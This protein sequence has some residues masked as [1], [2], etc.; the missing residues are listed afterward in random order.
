MSKTSI[1]WTNRSANPIRARHK[2]TGK[3][4]WHCVKKSPGCIHCYS[5]TLNGRFGTQLPFLKRSEDEVKIILDMRPMNALRRM[6]KGWM[7]F[8]CDMTDLFADFV[9]TDM[10]DQIMD[11]IVLC[12]QHTFQLLTKRPDRAR[13]YFRTRPVPDNVWMGC[14]VEDQRW[15]DERIPMLLEIMAKVRFLSYEPALSNVDLTRYLQ[16]LHWIICGGESGTNGI[17]PF[18]LDWARSTIAQCRAAGVACFIKQLGSIPTENGVYI[19]LHDR[20]GG[21]WTEWPEDLRVRQFPA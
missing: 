14:S 2:R 3:V 15:A 5:E 10:I 4:G 12:P 17:N 18:E 16:D 9:S 1:E 11:A 19:P 13:D 20:K 7:V 6:R 8:L 21:D